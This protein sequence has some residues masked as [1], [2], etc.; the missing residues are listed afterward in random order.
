MQLSLAVGLLVLL[1]IGGS[2]NLGYDESVI[3]TNENSTLLQLLHHLVS[4]K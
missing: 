4:L 3:E 1:G 2:L